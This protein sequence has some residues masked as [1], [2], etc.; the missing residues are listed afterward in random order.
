MEGNQDGTDVLDAEDAAAA[1]GVPA[2]S[3]EAEVTVQVNQDG[4]LDVLTVGDAAA[5]GEGLADPAFSCV[6]TVS[7]A[8]DCYA[9]SRR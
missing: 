2:V 4:T 8:V 7:A 3:A 6:T 1:A 5:A 9:R